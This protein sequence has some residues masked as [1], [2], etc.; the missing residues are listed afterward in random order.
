[1]KI[2]HICN[3]FSA[4]K[5]H[6]SLYQ[7]LDALDV[8]QTIFSPVRDASL[9]GNNV[10]KSLHTDFV[11]ANVVK[12]YHKYVYHLK[13]KHVFSEMLK[14]VDVRQFNLCH[15]TTLLTDGGLAYLLNKKYHIPY[16]VA[17]RSTDIN[18]FFDLMPHTWFSAKKILLHA[19]RIFFISKALQKQFKEHRAVRSVI[20]QIKDKMVLIPN[21]IDDFFLDRVHHRSHTGHG[22]IYVGDFSSNKNVVRLGEAVL[23]LKKE[24]Q[25]HDIMLTIVGGGHDNSNS[26]QKM[27][28]NHPDTMNY[29]GK[30][31]DKEK[32]CSLYSNN[33]VFAMPSILETFGLVYLEALSQNLPVLYTKGQGID[34]L[35]SESIGI[36]VNPLSVDE[37]AISLRRLLID[38]KY[39][40]AGVDFSRFRWDAIAHKYLEYYKRIQ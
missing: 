39:S 18:V 21:G 19:E 31:Y 26:V 32:L 12:P 16:F 13:R 14:R 10:F 37:I 7:K 38:E 6:A 24:Q 33:R 9:I 11:Y 22:I 29:V 27:I 8:E 17:V 23:K 40:N 30:I 2:L 28:S 3:D 15:A 34:G 25:F 36:A 4:S 20:P 35:F 1:M 5:V